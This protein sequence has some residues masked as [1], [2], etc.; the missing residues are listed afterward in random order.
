MKEFEYA[1]ALFKQK[2]NKGFELLE[3]NF[4]RNPSVFLQELSDVIKAQKLRFDEC[5][6]IAAI[7]HRLKKNNISIEIY[8]LLISMEENLEKQIK[9]EKDP[10][11]KKKL[12]SFKAGMAFSLGR[13]YNDLGI[14]YVEVGD[15]DNAKD[16]ILK[17]YNEDVKH[18]KLHKA[19]LMPA[20][21][22][23]SLILIW[24]AKI[25]FDKKECFPSFLMGWVSVELSLMRIWFKTLLERNYSDN[26]IKWLGRLDIGVIIE[27]LYLVDKLTDEEKTDIDTLRGRR[28]D[29]IHATGA[30]PTEGES[31]RVI[32]LAFLL[33]SKG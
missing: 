3:E 8:K 26:K 2:D 31:R 19:A 7:F 14:T 22:N 21:K 17:A 29:I 18:Q 20:Y 16:M 15:K 23:L 13:D 5:S 25:F 9:R 10:E 12:I 27:S 33:H 32:D 6:T 24:E 11:A 30:T 1:L 28:N 4:K